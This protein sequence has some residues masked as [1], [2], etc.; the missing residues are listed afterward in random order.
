MQREHPNCTTFRICFSLYA[1]VGGAAISL[2]RRR[3]DGTWYPRRGPLNKM[4]ADWSIEWDI[5]EPSPFVYPE[6]REVIITTLPRGC[7]INLT[8]DDK[9]ILS[10]SRTY[11]GV[12]KKFE[13]N[14]FVCFNPLEYCTTLVENGEDVLVRDNKTNFFNKYETMYYEPSG[15]LRDQS[16]ATTTKT[17]RQLDVFPNSHA[18]HNPRNNQH[19]DLSRWRRRSPS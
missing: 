3:L 15:L 14:N 12:K 5:K 1:V 19:P 16:L 11:E 8:P 17:H 9:V 13:E 18:R 4:S 2:R 7:L 6:G 10:Q